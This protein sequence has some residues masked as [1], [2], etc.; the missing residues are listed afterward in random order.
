MSGLFGYLDPQSDLPPDT[1]E[2]MGHVMA[3][4]ADQSFSIFRAPRVGIGCISKRI[5]PGEGD[6]LVGDDS[7][8]VGMCFGRLIG[9]GAHDGTSDAATLARKA[10]LDDASDSCLASANGPFAAV[11][12]DER[13]A[14]L[15]LVT[16]RYGMYPVYVANHQSAVLFATQIKALLA[17]GVLSRKLNPVALT[18]MTTIGELVGEHT[19]LEGVRLLPA[20]SR[21]TFTHHA[22]SV[23]RYWHYSFTDRETDLDQTARRLGRRL[24]VAVERICST[25]GTV[26][27]PLSGGLDSR[28]VLA[29]TPDPST[30]PS[31]TWGIPGCRDMRY[32]PT[33]A[34][35]LQSPHYAYEYE[36]DHLERS[37]APGV[38]ITEGQLPSTDFHV[39]PFVDRMAQH[40]NVV[41]NGYAG[42]AVLGGNFTKAPW[43]HAADRA[44]AAAALW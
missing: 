31:F 36:P 44:N 26:G 16:D 12:W 34:R 27:V 25:S 15:E 24:E 40:C 14:T 37:A 33:A 43:W 2:K 30:V 41:L 17:V 22:Q 8:R 29:S 6:L 35:I 13:R 28:V 38:W 4:P 1:V 39:L 10:F 42:D 3:S 19:P 20:A 7:D 11:V 9:L 32:A 18:L 23:T 5:Y 21:A